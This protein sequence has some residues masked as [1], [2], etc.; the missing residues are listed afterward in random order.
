MFSKFE[1]STWGKKLAKRAL[2]T[3]QTDFERCVCV[4][5]TN[6]NCCGVFS[7]P[8]FSELSCGVAMGSVMC[9]MGRQWQKLTLSLYR[10]RYQAAVARK[11]TSAAVKKVFNKLKSASE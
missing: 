4:G 2:K 3:T 7:E 1:S 10:C 5:F 6:S 11:K 9:P 8:H